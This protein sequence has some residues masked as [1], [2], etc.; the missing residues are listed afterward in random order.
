MTTTGSAFANPEVWQKSVQTDIC[1]SPLMTCLAFRQSEPKIAFWDTTAEW[2]PWL[3]SQS[4]P[5]DILLIA[6]AESGDHGS[7]ALKTNGGGGGGTQRPLII[8]TPR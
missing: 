4:P 6:E 5:D 1:I 3:K 2:N 8:M 7:S